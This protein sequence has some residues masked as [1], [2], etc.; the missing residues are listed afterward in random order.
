VI[1]GIDADARVMGAGQESVAG[2]E[3]GAKHAKVLVA[4]LLKPVDAAADID[5]R[6]AAGREGAADVGAD[7]VV[8]PLQLG[9]PAN[10]VVGLGEPQR[11]DAHAIEERAERVVAECIGI[12]LRHDH[13]GLLG[14]PGIL[15]RRRG[16]PARVH[17]VVLRV[18]RALGRGEAQELPW[19]DLALGGLLAQRGV[20]SQ[21]L[22]AH[23]GGEELRRARLPSGSRWGGDS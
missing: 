1:E 10:V 11:G 15:V 7:G 4:L 6:L 17:Q 21:R 18:G 20:V 2:A 9:G 22:G 19:R 12:P 5:H 16:I 23:V 3:A 8:G 14:P 13:D